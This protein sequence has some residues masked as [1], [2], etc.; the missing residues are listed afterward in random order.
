MKT[1]FPALPVSLAVLGFS[2][3]TASAGV[4]ADTS[5]QVFKGTIKTK[6]QRLDADTNEKGSYSTFV[7]YLQS[8]IDGAEALLVVNPKAKTF[9]IEHTGAAAFTLANDNHDLFNIRSNDLRDL[10]VGTGSL[11]G[12]V[13]PATFSEVAIDSYTPSLAYEFHSF[14]PAV[15]TLYLATHDKANLKADK[16]MMKLIYADGPTSISDAL[17]DVINYLAS[18]GY[19]GLA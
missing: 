9:F 1:R 14:A 7:Y 4:L 12:K 11:L 3:M 15:G 5:V 19:S 17:T 13:K 2:A 10:F 8:R 6:Y 16:A 18:K